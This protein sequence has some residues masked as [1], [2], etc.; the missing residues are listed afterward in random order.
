MRVSASILLASPVRTLRL[1]RST[2][3]PLP[4][5]PP[6]HRRVVRCPGVPYGPGPL[7]DPLRVRGRVLRPV[8]VQDRDR[9]ERLG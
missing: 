3:A 1:E 7:P 8:H 4:L 5:G 2:V 9:T 6:A